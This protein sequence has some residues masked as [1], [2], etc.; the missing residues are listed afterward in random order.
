MKAIGGDADKKAAA[1]KDAEK[2]SEKK[3]VDDE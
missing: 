2:E 3:K 1:D